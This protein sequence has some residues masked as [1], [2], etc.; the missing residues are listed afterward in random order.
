[1][2]QWKPLSWCKHSTCWQWGMGCHQRDWWRQPCHLQFF[3]PN[4]IYTAEHFP[5]QPKVETELYK[6]GASSHMSPFQD[7]QHSHFERKVLQIKNKPGKIIRNIP[8][9]SN[10]LYKVDH[11]H[12]HTASAASTVEHVDMYTLHQHLNHILA[13]AIW[14]LI[15]NVT[16]TGYSPIFLALSP[17]H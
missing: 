15:H 5:H 11:T 14:S 13:D 2:Q 17:Y 7:Q 4:T 3:I 10:G 1:M 9:N 16:D 6:S 8:A 12:S